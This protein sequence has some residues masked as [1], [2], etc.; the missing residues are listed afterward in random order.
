MK[1]KIKKRR[2]I[3]ISNKL[4]ISELNNKTQL[5]GEGKLEK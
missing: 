1:Q 3:K 2:E 4:C 5:D